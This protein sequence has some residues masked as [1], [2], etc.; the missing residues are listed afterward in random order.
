MRL[1]VLVLLSL[2]ARQA[3]A[4]AVQ[5]PLRVAADG[6]HLEDQRGAPFLIHGDAAWTVVTSLTPGEAVQ[7]LDERRAQ[8]FNTIVVSALVR[9]FGGP[10]NRAGDAPFVG[11]PADWRL[12]NEPYWAHLDGLLAQARDRDMLVLLAPA[13]VGYQCGAE[14]WCAEML[15]QSVAVMQQYGR[16]LA[17]RYRNQSNLLW[18]HGGDV[19]PALFPGIE[20]RINAIATV[21]KAEGGPVLH[22]AHC[23]RQHSALDCAYG[24]EPWL[25]VNTTYSDCTSSADALRNDHE[26]RVPPHPF[27]YIEGRYENEGS[28]Q[29]CLANQAAWSDTGGSAGHLFGNRPVWLF[30]VG[31]DQP[32]GL[33]SLG[34]QTM[35]RLQ[36]VMRSRA[37]WRGASDWAR[38]VVVAGAASGGD[39]VTALRTHEGETIIAHDPTALPLSID[40][41]QLRGSAARGWWYHL[42]TGLITDLGS[43]PSTGVRSFAPPFA[44]SLLVLDD[45]AAGLAAPGTSVYPP[46]GTRAAVTQL[47]ITRLSP[48]LSPT[49]RLQLRW[50]PSP[51]ATSYRLYWDSR[52]GGVWPD[53]VDCGN[54]CRDLNGDGTLDRCETI[55]DEA[56][57]GA[58][59]FFT[60]TARDA[61]SES[62]TN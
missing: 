50:Q 56:T 48:P 52:A 33:G 30:D 35:Q 19:E 42:E 3:A 47:Q 43:F 46:P 58:L 49:P 10:L 45:T 14:G 29:L 22:T 20:A 27:I 26:S 6:R 41:D 39:T 9:S 28:S 60:V 44:G 59:R 34:A 8:G 57:R 24:D 11:G 61:T 25:D 5:W 23:D 54:P 15:A 7:Y 31:W 38:H 18:V 51:G 12:P 4:A 40:L 55:W 36:L 2:F 37:W 16:F 53:W 17:T 62:S 21:L 13:Y 1:A 32:I